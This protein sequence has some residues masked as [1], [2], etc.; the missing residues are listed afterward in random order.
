MLS[1]ILPLESDDLHKELAPVVVLK[2]ILISPVEA[3]SE[4]NNTYF[5][6]TYASDDSTS[7]PR[8]RHAPSICGILQLPKYPIYGSADGY[9]SLLEQGGVIVAPFGQTRLSADQDIDLPAEREQRWA[10]KSP[11]PIWGS[12]LWR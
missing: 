12:S 8:T 5:T 4:M 10:T 6:T 9:R 3:P 11:A 1:L 2:W 7:W